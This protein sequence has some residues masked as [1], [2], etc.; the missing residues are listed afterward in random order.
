MKLLRFLQDGSYTRMGGNQT[1]RANVRI[2]SAVQPRRMGSLRD[3]LY[4]RVSDVELRTVPLREMKERDIANIACN[5]AYRLMWRPVMNEGGEGII[6]PDFIREIW[7]QLTLPQHSACLSSYSWP[8]NMR[9]LST[10]I[11]RFVLLGDDIFDELT[12]KLTDSGDCPCESGQ[13]YDEEWKRFLLPVTSME[14]LERRQLKLK[15]LQS[16]FV[17]NLIASL[18]GRENVQTTKLAEILGCSY[19]TLVS[20]IA[21]NT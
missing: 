3:D 11:K 6:T 16:A 2:L 18:G 10:M 13:G 9:E 21:K 4:Y 8:G 12:K 1:L 20:Y 19:N 7:R 5:L 15:N 14:I 17:R